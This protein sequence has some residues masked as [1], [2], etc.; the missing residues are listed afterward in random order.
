MVN[1]GCS[2]EARVLVTMPMKP[3]SADDAEEQLVTA[4]SE[5]DSSRR[6]IRVVQR[7]A[8]QVS[9]SPRKRNQS[10]DLSRTLRA[11]RSIDCDRLAR[12]VFVSS[13]RIVA[14][15]L[16]IVRQSEQKLSYLARFLGGIFDKFLDETNI[17]ARDRIEI[18]D[19]IA[20]ER[21]R[22]VQIKVESRPAE[23]WRERTDKSESPTSF[24][25][26]VYADRLGRGLALSDIRQLDRD[27][28]RAYY[29]ARR[30]GSVEESL[31]LETKKQRY[32]AL[33]RFAE[34]RGGFDA[35]AELKLSPNELVRLK[36]VAAKRASRGEKSAEKPAIGKKQT[37]ETS[38]G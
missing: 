28:Y 6:K 4:P 38:T 24:I 17:S 35:L 10:I 11:Q 12:M 37:P 14:E 8:A 25:R 18:L 7:Q 34:E 23:R 13:Q 21:H 15:D 3:N 30:R 22:T 5:T 27:L 32:D 2:D 20:R 29:N 19:S 31:S 9:A 16:N 1:A 26:R 36:A 33:L